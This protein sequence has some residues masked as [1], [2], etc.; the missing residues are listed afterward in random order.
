MPKTIYITVLK[1]I[2][3]L[4]GGLIALILL[5]MLVIPYVFKDQINNTLK[6]ITNKTISGNLDY[7]DIDVSF[8]R[9]FP[10]LTTAVYDVKL[11]GSAPFQDSTLLAVKEISI[12][13]D[14]LS[15][16]GDKIVLDKLIIADGKIN[17]LVDS[18]GA[19]NY[20]IYSNPDSTAQTNDTDTTSSQIA[21]KLLKLENIDLHYLDASI[22]ML[23]EG[24]N[25]DYEGK[26]DLNSA[27][28]DLKTNAK[29]EAFSFTFDNEKYIENK[30][31]DAQLITQINTNDL[32]LI[33]EKNDI[34]INQLPVR[35]KGAFAFLSNG[36]HLDFKLKSQESTL[37]ELL[38]LVPTGYADWLKDTEVKGTTEVFM[39]LE[40]DYIADEHKMPNLALGLIIND[41]YMSY[42]NAKTP[43]SAWNAKFKIE[44]PQLN[45]DSLAI[46]LNQF[47]FKVANGFFKTEGQIKGVDPMQI[48]STV[49]S[50]LDLGNLYQAVQWPAFSFAGQLDLNGHIEGT[51]STDT[52]TY[53]LRNK[54]EAYISSIPTF[55]IK[56]TLKNGYFKMAS[57]PAA[58]EKIAYSLEASAKD[59]QIK[60]A[61]I[62]IKDIDIAA[63]NN[64][65]KGYADIKDFQKLHLDANIQ[66]DIDLSDIKKIY[67]IE[68]ADIAGNIFVNIISQGF[69]DLKKNIVP[70]TNATVTLKKGHFKSTEYPMPLE[71]IH[72]ETYIES[73]KGS[74]R[75]L[76][77]KILPVSFK[78]A[79]EP[80]FLHADFQNFNNIKYAIKS[81]GRLN[82]GPIYKLFALEGT[83]V[84]GYI[85]TDV[86]LAGLQ[87]DA[88]QGRYHRLKNEGSINV[89]NVR[90][91]TELL[92]QDIHI[93]SGNFSFKQ[94]KLNFDKFVTQ[95]GNNEISIKGYINN[96]IN[97]LTL[98]SD[99]LKGRFDLRSKK[100]NLDDFMAFSTPTATSST[101]TSNSGVILLP[102]LL[103]IEVLSMVDHVYYDQMRL[104]NFKG[105]LKLKS[106]NL[107]LD[108]TGFE[109]AGLK[110]DMAINYRPL[111]PYKAKFDFKVKADSFDIQRAYKEIPLFQQMV[112]S[113]KDAH[114]IISL[115]YQLAGLLDGD[116]SPIM[117]SIQGQ[118]VLSLNKIRFKNFK[119]LN[120]ISKATSKEGFLNSDLK[121]VNIRTSIRNNVMTIERTKMKMAGFRPRF[122]GQVTLDGRMNIGFRLGLP[123]LGILGIPMRINGTSDNFKIKLGRYKE[124]DLDTEMDDEDKAAYDAS[125]QKDS[126]ATN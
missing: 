23:I 28:F 105:N 113:A 56:N 36:Y 70:E 108:N 65:I 13:I 110:T 35:F 82:L 46:D 58:I 64:F 71:D 77:I 78:L 96:I 44:L 5:A 66:A 14:L 2:S 16:F 63:L 104:K 29:I 12:G 85:R 31:I 22:P 109:L 52:L 80:F 17:V 1:R 40:G 54:K 117:P 19:A 115:D 48:H 86:D 61:K 15:L 98:N 37:N 73:K 60:N 118:G 53:G 95:Y 39:N 114:G 88:L 92:P 94:E 34:R 10:A 9:H 26:G 83:D 25:I 62:A 55:N 102:D 7:R 84:D 125:L 18:L 38:S 68:S 8:F 123:P 20:N 90:V 122:E 121:K 103:D 3:Y 43:I 126:V 89:G 76:K 99:V 67:P 21:F 6:E 119:L 33:F 47:E 74:L 87:S 75:D 100:I 42:K 69:M 101:S 72:V 107:A 116:M 111:N 41:G 4:F 81:K 30:S 11:K 51:Y 59:H 27:I 45:P 57:L 32:S 97:Y 79:G 124:D 112:T 120:G 93:K 49:N 91:N 106:G 24:K 50:S